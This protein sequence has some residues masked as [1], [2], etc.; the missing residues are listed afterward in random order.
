MLNQKEDSLLKTFFVHQLKTKKSKDWAAD[1][2]KDLKSFD[3][4]LTMEEIQNL[5]EETWK[6]LVKNKSIENT[7]KELNFKQGSKSQQKRSLTMA[8]YLRFHSEDFSI[9]T[10]SFIA[11]I[12]THIVEGIKSNFKEQYLP[13][14]TCKSCNL[15]ECNQMH[16]LEC[17]A[18]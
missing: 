3:I 14:L 4:N 11:K 17:S 12:Q 15:S 10:A 5:P 18:L 9:K 6:L 16:L 1:I 13:N 8:P 7:L 2:L